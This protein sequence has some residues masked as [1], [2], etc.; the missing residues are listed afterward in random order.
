M[1]GLIWWKR[2]TEEVNIYLDEARGQRLALTRGRRVTREL[3][4][5]SHVGAVMAIY[6][7][8][9]R[10]SDDEEASEPSVLCGVMSKSL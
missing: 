5:L 6:H 3:Y 10:L 2:G 7:Q 4:N 1:N 8:L 9:S